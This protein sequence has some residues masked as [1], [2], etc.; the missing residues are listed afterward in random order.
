MIN[1]VSDAAP[2]RL[3]HPREQLATMLWRAA[4][5]PSTSGNLNSYVDAS[6]VSDWAVQV[7]GWAVDKGILSGMGVGALVPQTTVTRA[8]VSVMLIQFVK[9]MEV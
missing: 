6:S 4:G 1:G 3:H 9:N 2:Q 7:L 5:S 8:K